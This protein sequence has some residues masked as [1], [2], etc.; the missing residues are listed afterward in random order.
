MGVEQ[1]NELP[2]TVVA[3]GK[4]AAEQQ[5]AGGV[6]DRDRERVFVGIYAGEHS[7]NLHSRCDRGVGDAQAFWGDG[8][9][10]YLTLPQASIGRPRRP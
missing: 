2:E 1:P 5:P 7:P 8:A 4:L 3:V 9:T 10:A 6:D